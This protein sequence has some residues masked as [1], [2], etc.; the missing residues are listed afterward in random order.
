MSLFP[1]PHRKQR[2][3]SDIP[4]R[5]S[6]GSQA[7]GGGVAPGLAPGA[8]GRPRPAA[9]IRQVNVPVPWI[10]KPPEA[11]EINIDASA[12]GFT[13]ANTPQVIAGS[14]F[15]VP[16][17]N[18]GVIRSVVLN[19]NTMLPA[20]LLTWTLRFDQID[21]E[22]WQGLTIFPRNAGSVSVAYGPDE[23]MI[24]I[25]EGNV[26]DAVINVGAADGNTYQAGI[27]Y[28]GWSYP[29]RLADAFATLYRI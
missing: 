3:P 19:L 13:A 1:H 25:P 28:H 16:A 15:T 24:M 6:G 23:T 27:T 5:L 22:G 4:S 21:V 12:A 9:P 11:R 20:S 7:T 29:K 8:A 2:V 17:N 14:A 10:V 18:V 26:I